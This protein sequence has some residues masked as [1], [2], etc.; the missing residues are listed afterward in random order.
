[1]RLWGCFTGERLNGPVCRPAPGLVMM[2]GL[3]HQ[4]CPGVVSFSWTA[5][6]D[7]GGKVK[8]IQR[9]DL[10]DDAET[11]A[12]TCGLLGCRG[13][14]HVSLVML[15][16]LQGEDA[17]ICTYWRFL[18][19]VCGSC[20]RIFSKEIHISHFLLRLCLWRHSACPL[21]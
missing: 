10:I 19:E 2:N 15:V 8:K 7:L 1:M 16:L 12:L 11:R 20:C 17:E 5:R 13:R 21:G 18:M 9:S 4:L 14:R 6:L 3:T